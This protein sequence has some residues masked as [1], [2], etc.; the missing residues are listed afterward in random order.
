MIHQ[1]RLSCRLLGSRSIERFGLDTE[2]LLWRLA[3]FG[4]V[5]CEDF[6]HPRFGNDVGR[7][8]GPI[9]HGLAHRQPAHV[10]TLTRIFPPFVGRGSWQTEH[11]RWKEIPTGRLPPLGVESGYG[12]NLAGSIFMERLFRLALTQ[13]Q[14]FN[15]TDLPCCLRHLV[16]PD[17][18]SGTC[19]LVGKPSPSPDEPDLPSHARRSRMT[20]Q[21]FDAEALTS[22][23]LPLFQR[24]TPIS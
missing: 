5:F 6:K 13:P 18:N 11:Q 2:L 22:P 17:L 20:R 12:T 14:S 8:H 10:N 7:H 21:P 9:R 16:D 1:S 15:P 3:C 19:L 23:P 4:R 24:L